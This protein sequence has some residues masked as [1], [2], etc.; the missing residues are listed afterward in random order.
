MN[1]SQAF[2][3]KLIY[4]AFVKA[5][6]LLG[7]GWMGWLFWAYSLTTPEEM[8]HGASFNYSWRNDSGCIF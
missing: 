5:L 8:I 6:V 3:L 1:E 4:E 2:T 7:R